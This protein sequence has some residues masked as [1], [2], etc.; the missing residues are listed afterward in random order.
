MSFIAAGTVLLLAFIAGS[1]SYIATPY[2]ERQ[3]QLK[4]KNEAGDDMVPAAAHA[5]RLKE[6]KWKTW[7][8][9]FGSSVLCALPIYFMSNAGVNTIDLCRHII[10]TIFLL[11][12]MIVD[13]KTHLI[14]NIIVLIYFLVGVLLMLCEFIVYREEATK[15]LLS[16]CIGLIGCLL[17]F[18]VLSRLTKNGISM[19]DVKLIAVMGWILGVSSALFS[20]L[21]AMIICAV[22]GLFLLLS[23][24]KKKN[25]RVPFGPFMFLGYIIMLLLFSI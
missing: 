5:L 20:V 11:S 3:N 21:F 7:I 18:Y 9:L 10:V 19:G 13:W 14:P 23:K 1:V 24:Q 4:S 17:L 16:S 25:D 6:V 22:V 15:T 2:I 12:V 8:V